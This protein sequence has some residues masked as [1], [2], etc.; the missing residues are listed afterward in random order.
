MRFSTFVC[1]AI[2]AATSVMAKD[3]VCVVGDEAV[4]TVDLD[5]GVCPFTL[6]ADLPV[7]WDFESLDDYDVTAYYALLNATK[8]FNNI[9]KAGRDIEIPAKLIYGGGPVPLFRIDETKTPATNS[10]AALRRRLLGKTIY[11]R[12]EESDTIAYLE[13]LDGSSVSAVEFSV[14]DVSVASSL[15]PSADLTSTVTDAETTVITI[16]SCSANKCSTT[17]VPAVATVTTVTIDDEVTSYTTYCPLTA[18]EAA[19]DTV[20]DIETT[21]ITITSCVDNKCST[22][23]V[24]TGLTTVTEEET[25]YT[26]YCPLTAEESTEDETS[27]LYV[28]SYV[29]ITSCG[30]AGCTPTS[31]VETVTTVTI[32]GVE[33]AYTTLCPVTA[34]EATAVTSAT[35][36]ASSLTFSPIVNS[37]VAVVNSTTAAPVGSLAAGAASIV[38]SGDSCDTTVTVQ[39]TVT[40]STSLEA[41]ATTEAGVSTVEAGANTGVTSVFAVVIAAL[42]WLI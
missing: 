26:T 30:E 12:D 15:D 40:L 37:T 3:V 41:G 39:A 28:T 23:A 18:E 33:T 32:N 27:T 24:T 31:L 22:S 9:A 10:T 8:Y 34:E 2:L 11:A 13:T 14:V 7:V 17:A 5:T 19:A 21:V 16:T 42:A 36:V 35:A 6:P 1:S 29:T 4:A 25:I 38:C 20:T